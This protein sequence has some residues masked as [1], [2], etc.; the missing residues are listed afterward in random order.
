MRAWR[1]SAARPSTASQVG[2]LLLVGSED[3][4][5]RNGF[6]PDAEAARHILGIGHAAR[7]RVHAG[8]RQ[9]VHRIGPEGIHRDHGHERRVDATGEPEHHLTEA[10]LAHVVARAE[11]ERAIHLLGLGGPGRPLLG[12]EAVVV[13]LDDQ[14]VFVEP[15]GATGD[16]AIRRHDQRSSVEHELVLP[17][18]GVDVD[19]PG[20]G[21]GGTRPQDV[22]ALLHLAAV[23]RRPVEVDDDRRADVAVERW[24]RLPGVLADRQADVGAGDLDGD[25]FGAGDERPAFVEDAVVRQLALRVARRDRPALQHRGR[26]VHAGG[27]PIHEPDDDVAA[28]RPSPARGRRPWRACRPRTPGAARGPP[29]GSR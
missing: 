15:R 14:E 22:G 7:A 16:R 5:D 21:L 29:A 3:V 18:D 1:F 25:A 13:D 12:G 4:G 17:A 10:V 23:E 9:G 20:A 26:V 28:R 2:E 24:A 11:H 19:D 27:R 6:E 8:H